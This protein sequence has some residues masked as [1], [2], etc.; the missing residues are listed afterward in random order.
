MTESSKGENR[1]IIFKVIN[2]R[3]A[4]GWGETTAGPRPHGKFGVA[5]TAT[6]CLDPTSALY[7]PQCLS[8]LQLPLAETWLMWHLGFPATPQYTYQVSQPASQSLKM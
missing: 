2:K 1:K 5:G 6:D 8:F 3:G 4:E 7:P